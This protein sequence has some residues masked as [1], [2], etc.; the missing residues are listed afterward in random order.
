MLVNSLSR[1]SCGWRK[2]E[3]HNYMVERQ[4]SPCKILMHSG[5]KEV[6][7]NLKKHGCSFS[8]DVFS[9]ESKTL[10]SKFYLFRKGSIWL[11]CGLDS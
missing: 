9:A 2:G 11:V 10:W 7:N 5:M 4:E 6:G 3:L 8:D 1:Y